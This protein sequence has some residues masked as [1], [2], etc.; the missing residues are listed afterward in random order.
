MK[1]A[2]VLA[3]GLALTAVVVGMTGCTAGTKAERDQLFSEN[4]GLRNEV[5]DLNQ[6]LDACESDRGGM[7]ADLAR[8]RDDN[9][10]LQAQLD[11]EAAVTV[12]QDFGFGGIP[13][14]TGSMSAG[15]VSARVE[16]DVLFA[17]GQVTLK[18]TAKATLDS[19]AAVL[20]STYGGM[21]IR[22]E[23]H[24][25]SDPIKKSSWKTN[26]RL[27]AERAMA[28]KEYLKTR[29][30]AASR[31]YIAGFG[32]NRQLGSKEKSRRV[33]IVVLLNK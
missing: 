2:R 12:D 23:G 28:V 10:A 3:C 26:D 15:E 27:S 20:N 5:A 31:I 33:E 32:L 22:I 29:G 11:A 25:D 4:Q 21:T 14:V 1:F 19:V 9:A 6:A 13:G 17:A 30:V 24:T 18:K 7:A 8:Y 16:G